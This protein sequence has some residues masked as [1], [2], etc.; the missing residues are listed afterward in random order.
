MSRQQGCTEL[1]KKTFWLVLMSAKAC[2]QYFPKLFVQTAELNHVSP[3]RNTGTKK[4][5][6]FLFRE[7]FT[8]FQLKCQAQLFTSC[9]T[10]ERDF[11]C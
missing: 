10:V 2:F 1:A 11:S 8:V 9:L 5:V 7:N 3:F 4:K 6:D